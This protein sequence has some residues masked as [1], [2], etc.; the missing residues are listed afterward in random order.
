M[1]TISL[2]ERLAPVATGLALTVMVTVAGADVSVPSLA[3]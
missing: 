3:V 2:V 1:A